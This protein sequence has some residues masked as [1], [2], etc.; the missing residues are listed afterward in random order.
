[1]NLENMLED[2][3]KFKQPNTLKKTKNQE[4]FIY[5]PLIYN[6]HNYGFMVF[7]EEKY[8][9]Y[10]KKL[11]D[12]QY[13]HRYYYYEKIDNQNDKNVVFV[14]FNPS[15]AC[16]IKDDPTIRNCRILAKKYQYGSMEIINIFSERNPE[17]EEIDTNNNSENKQFIELFLK[18]RKNLDIVLA[19]GYG[20]E[21]EY[22]KQIDQIKNL[23]NNNNKYKITINEEA[24][25]SIKNLDRHPAPSCWSAFNGFENAAELTKY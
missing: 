13:K 4:G 8:K 6:N 15:Y 21:K 3:E 5:D 20:K 10:L 24:F 25:K 14:M 16:P 19:W 17:V 1:M 23:L 12:Y 9:K 2:I 22:K 7:S 18:N 11:Y